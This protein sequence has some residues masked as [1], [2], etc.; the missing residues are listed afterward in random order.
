MKELDTVEVIEIV[1]LWVWRCHDLLWHFL[2]HCKD[3]LNSSRGLL[4][5]QEPTIVPL[6]RI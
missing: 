3:L 5:V 4:G 6:F 1:L 2:S